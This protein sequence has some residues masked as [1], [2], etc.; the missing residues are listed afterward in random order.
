MCAAKLAGLPVGRRE[1]KVQNCTIN[2]SADEAADLF[3]I[4]RTSVFHALKVLE[5]GSAALIEQ[6]ETGDLAVSLAADF[7]KA[8]PWLPSWPSSRPR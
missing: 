2:S 7:V 6:C 4:G 8:D 1:L 3:S 5:G